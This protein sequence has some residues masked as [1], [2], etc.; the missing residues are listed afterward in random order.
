[1]VES[2]PAWGRGLKYN[3]NKANQEMTKS[4]PAWGR[5]LK[6]LLLLYNILNVIVAP[7]V[8]AWIEIEDRRMDSDPNFVAPRV[9]AWIEI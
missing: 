2:P 3:A 8:G 6:F 4:P 1:M 9:G 7:R 5:G